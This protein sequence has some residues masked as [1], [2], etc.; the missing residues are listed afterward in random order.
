MTFPDTDP[1]EAVTTYVQPTATPT[2][3]IKAVGAAGFAASIVFLVLAQFGVTLDDNWSNLVV[4][5]I[6]VA[7]GY[8]KKSDTANGAEKK[9]N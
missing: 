9:V 3:K 5:L 2:A 1:K 6:A 7:A 8:F 4:A